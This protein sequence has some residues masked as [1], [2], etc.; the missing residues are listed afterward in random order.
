MRGVFALLIVLVF[1]LPEVLHAQ[2]TSGTQDSVLGGSLR[3]RRDTYIIVPYPN[4]ALHGVVVS[5]QYY[6]HN[7]EQTSL[8]IV[9]ALD[10]EVQVLQPQQLMT[11]GLHSYDLNTGLISTGT[12]FIRLTRYTA[13]GSNLEVLNERFV[14]V[15]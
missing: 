5:I 4:P 15:H 8:R 6:N 14:V 7:P 3:P 2:P 9:D 11:N 10:R 12:Y 13:D 1:A